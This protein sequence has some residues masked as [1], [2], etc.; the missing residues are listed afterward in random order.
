MMA[1]VTDS[2]PKGKTKQHPPWCTNKARGL[3]QD[4]GQCDKSFSETEIGPERALPGKEVS[5][6]AH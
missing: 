5:Q 1:F 4:Q 6:C 2:A 3:L